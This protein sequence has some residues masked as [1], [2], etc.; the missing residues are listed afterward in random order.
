[1]TS[2]EL[3]AWSSLVERRACPWWASRFAV[4]IAAG[5][6]IAAW[7]RVAQAR[8]LGLGE[9]RVAGRRAAAIALAAGHLRRP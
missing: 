8:G 6:A 4:A 2:R 1:M 5:A 9:P 7:G 3:I